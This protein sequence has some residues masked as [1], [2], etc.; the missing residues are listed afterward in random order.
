MTHLPK[1]KMATM[2]GPAK[3]VSSK[4]P[5]RADMQQFVNTAMHRSSQASTYL[6]SLAVQ[7]RNARHV[8]CLLVTNATTGSVHHPGLPVSLP[9]NISLNPPARKLWF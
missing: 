3:R 8:A 6:G 5:C 4:M 1:Q 7:C 2:T 9:D